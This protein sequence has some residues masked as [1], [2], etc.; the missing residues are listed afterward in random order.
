MES[1]L[2][3]LPIEGSGE[4]SLTVCKDVFIKVELSFYIFLHIIKI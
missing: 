4:D 1:P 3:P 2:A